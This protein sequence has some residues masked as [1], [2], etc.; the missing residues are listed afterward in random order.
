MGSAFEIVVVALLAAKMDHLAFNHPFY[1]FLFQEIGAAL[2]I[3]DKFGVGSRAP[4]LI[5][6]TGGG[7]KRPAD[8]FY[9]KVGDPH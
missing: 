3:A 5:P 7:K 9:K 1:T 4:H 2:R 6:K 8:L